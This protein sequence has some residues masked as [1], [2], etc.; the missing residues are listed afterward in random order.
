L[1]KRYG[2][3]VFR[4]VATASEIADLENLFWDWLEREHPG[5]NRAK[6][7]THTPKVFESLGH[8]NSGIVN[9]GSIG[10]SDFLWKARQ[11]TG[12][13]DAWRTVWGLDQSEPA[14]STRQLLTS[15]D[16]CGAW[17]NPSHPFHAD[18]RVRTSQ[19]W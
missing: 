9:T 18:K 5:V 10:Q 4:A 15:F 7:S 14:T 1:L 19:A 11:L 2:C 12:V 8:K 13:I 3:V 17:R 6:P 16:G